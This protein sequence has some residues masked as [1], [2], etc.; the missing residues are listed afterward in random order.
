M[1]SGRAAAWVLMAPPSGGVSGKRLAV[2]RAPEDL[3]LWTKASWTNGPVMLF[4]FVFL[5]GWTDITVCLLT[6]LTLSSVPG[7]F[8]N[9]VEL[10]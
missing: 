10:G 2:Y 1:G 8:K 6:H 4:W 7:Q 9:G 5:T 3:G